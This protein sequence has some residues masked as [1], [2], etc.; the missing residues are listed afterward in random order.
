MDT[1]LHTKLSVTIPRPKKGELSPQEILES[2]GII[3]K[4]A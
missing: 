4:E 1:S 2:E 3:I